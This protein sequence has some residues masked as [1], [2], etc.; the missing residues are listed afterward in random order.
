MKQ[1][2]K[3]ATQARPLNYKIKDNEMLSKMLNITTFIRMLI[4]WTIGK[5]IDL[6]IL[7]VL[8]RVEG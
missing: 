3:K 2:Q 5:D 1:I 7:N 4:S 8:K 6:T